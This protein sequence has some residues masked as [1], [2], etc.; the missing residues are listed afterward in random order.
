MRYR[1]VRLRVLKRWLAVTL[2]GGDSLIDASQQVAECHAE[3]G[4]DGQESSQARDSLSIFNESHGDAMQ[5]AVIGKGFL[6]KSLLC[7]QLPH[8]LP[9][10]QQDLLHSKEFG[11]S[12]PL[13]PQTNCRQTYCYVMRRHES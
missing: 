13:R 8:A 9:Q 6:T 3:S 7:P 10:S 12:I 4:R 1:P 5:S 11:G 2:F